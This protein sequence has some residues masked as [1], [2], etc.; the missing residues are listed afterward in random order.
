MAEY[1]AIKEQ[2]LIGTLPSSGAR[3]NDIPKSSNRAVIACCCRWKARARRPR[4]ASSSPRVPRRKPIV[5][6]VAAVGPGKA[7]DDGEVASP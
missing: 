2:D 6:T 4:G 5:G 3:A 7:D 1:S